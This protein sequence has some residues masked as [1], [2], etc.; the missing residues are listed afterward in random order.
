MPNNIVLIGFEQASIIND[1]ANMLKSQNQEVTIQHPDDFLAG[2][3]SVD[4]QYMVCVTR[5]LDLRYSIIEK[6][7]SD[8]LTRGTFVHPSCWIDPTA[9]IGQ[10]SF[11]GPFCTVACGAVLG[12]DTCV[13][14]YTMISHKATIGQ[15]T[16]IHTGAL[17][18]GSTSIGQR[19]TI[20]VR[21]TLIDKITVC[22]GVTIGAGSLVTKN[23]DTPGNYIGSP[24]R[25]LNKNI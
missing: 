4:K 12:K 6:L 21:A 7:D 17:I 3:V 11:V 19:C 1:L 15:G 18:A 10:G 24:A 13:G 20:N 2:N 5:D 8:Q 16:L 22:D 9:I 23:I 14:P 25:N